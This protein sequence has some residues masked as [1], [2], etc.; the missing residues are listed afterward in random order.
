MPFRASAQMIF[1]Q[2]LIVNGDA[3]A[4]SA[5][6]TGMSSVSSIPGWTKTGSVDVLSYSSDYRISPSAPQLIPLSHGA[7]YFSSGP[8]T[9]ALTS[10]TQSIDLSSAASSIDAGTVS[11]ALSAYLGGYS[12]T[13]DSAAFSVSFLGTAG[14]TLGTLPA[15]SVTVTDRNGITG[16]EYR[17]QIGLVPSGTRTASVT[18]VLNSTATI[19]N[20]VFADNLSL[21]LNAPALP[22]SVFGPNLIVN[23]G[24]EAGPAA[25]VNNVVSD[26]PDWSRT[27]NFTV[28]SY[29][30]TAGDMPIAVGL[31]SPGNNFFY[32]GVSNEQSMAFQECDISPAAGLIDAGKVNFVLSGWLGGYEEQGDNAMLTL[33]FRDWANNTIGS[34]PQIGPVSASDREGITELLQRSTNGTVPAG[35]RYVYL[36]LTMTRLNEIFNDGMADG[37]SLVLSSSVGPPASMLIVSGNNQ[38]G[39]A[40]APLANPVVV[41]VLDNQMNPVPGVTVAFSASNAILTT[42]TAQTDS[43]GQASTEVTLGSNAGAASVTATVAGLTPATFT[44]TVASAPTLPTISAVVNGASFQPGIVSG[45][46]ASILGN[47]L[48]RDARNW[49][50]PDF[51]NG[52]LPI[53]LDQTAVT[54]NGK[55]A[56]V[57]YISS[58][59][60]NVILPDD[61][62][63]G[64]VAVQVTDQLGNSNTFSANKLA[65]SPALFTFTTRY[66]AAV[67]SNGTDIG[68]P[69]LLK[70]VITVPAAPGEVILIFGTG[71]GP[72][73][74]VIP[75][76]HLFSKAEPIAQP[77]TATVGNMA[78]DVQGFLVL[79]G[80]YQFNL[81]VPKLPPGDAKV[82]ITISGLSTQDGLYLTVG[83]VPGELLIPPDVLRN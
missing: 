42:T 71:F 79:S 54:V 61:P 23:G 7:N 12:S 11:A 75:T 17:R 52:A 47:N 3:E 44:L 22:Q 4:G 74:P 70:G 80:Q 83:P 33:Q 55:N 62:A 13:P 77:V 48:A 46:F 57:A 78:A 20:T 9:S 49:Q 10:L 50:G 16:M 37:L 6:P 36:L 81:I 56:F 69:N 72:T 32:G 21:V 60:L 27:G 40:G 63:T 28:D 39:Q 64:A 67:H 68:P 26:V 14:N 59:Q 38:T 15:G 65:L 31:S 66:P 73:S 24:A 53:E 76:G 35:A 2:N 29:S 1:G 19:D 58:T 18:L 5:D 8:A 51:V 82:V 30:D 25:N 34:S 43:S 45:S 41:Q